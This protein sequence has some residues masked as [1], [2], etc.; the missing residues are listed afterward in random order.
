MQKFAVIVAGGSGKRMGAELPKQFIALQGLPILMH[1]LKAFHFDD[2]KILLV[3]PDHQT[4]HWNQLVATHRF[5]VPHQLV[6]GGKER[7]HSV[8]NGLNTI[9]ESDGLVAIHD[10]VRPL[11]DRNIIRKS[12][13]IA[14]AKGSAVASIPLK[15]SIRSV[16]HSGNQ[17][18]DRNQFRLIQTPQTFQLRLIK[19]AFEQPYNT[20]FTDDASVLEAA[21]H[22]VH[23][24]E[25]NYKNI[26]ITTPEDLLIA[27]SFLNV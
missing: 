3:L 7:F 5:D 18:E 13:E 9:A 6:K 22:A 19:K 15:D 21:G 25:G 27:Q 17:Q 16:D 10:G 4:D 23:L 20:S 1:T 24:I 14:Y 8:Q 26:K 11:V 12:Y 2:I